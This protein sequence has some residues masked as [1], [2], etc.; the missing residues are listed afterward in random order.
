M[1]STISENLVK[2]TS[3][4][5]YPEPQS[6]CMNEIRVQTGL[7]FGR[8]LSNALSPPGG[9]KENSPAWSEAECWDRVPTALRAP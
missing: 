5:S 6:N 8:G 9:R 2:A 7:S 4:I 1:L 3:E